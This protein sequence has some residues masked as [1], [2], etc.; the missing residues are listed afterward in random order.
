[1]RPEVALTALDLY[2]L[3]QKTE[4]SL[5][6]GPELGADDAPV[7]DSKELPPPDLPPTK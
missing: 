7:Y 2:R 3:R 6:F 1:M 5:R 4:G